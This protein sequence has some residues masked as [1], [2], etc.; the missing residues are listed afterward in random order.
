ML[1]ILNNKQSRIMCVKCWL[2]G[3]LSIGRKGNLRY[4]IRIPLLHLDNQ[5]FYLILSLIVVE[6]TKEVIFY[7]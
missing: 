1:E 4:I 3:E 7:V 6:D 2:N 5:I